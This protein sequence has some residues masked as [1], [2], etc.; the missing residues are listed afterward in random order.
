MLYYAFLL[1]AARSGAHA[2]SSA[3]NRLATGQSQG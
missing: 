2:V 1:Q 3:V